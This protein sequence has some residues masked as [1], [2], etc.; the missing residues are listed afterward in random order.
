MPR[1][2]RATSHWYV[3]DIL[4]VLGATPVAGRVVED[5]RIMTGAG[6]TAGTDFALTLIARLVDEE[7]AHKIALLLEYDPEPP[8]AAGTPD[9]AGPELTTN[10]RS[11]RGE[12]IAA[13]RIAAER[14]AA[15]VPV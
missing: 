10:L 12:A 2:K 15:R 8:F 7:T 1:G 5:G 6:V 3:R 4:P 14:A 9:D 11:V 13:A